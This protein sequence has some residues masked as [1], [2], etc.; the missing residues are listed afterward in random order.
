MMGPLANQLLAVVPTLVF[1]IYNDNISLDARTS[2]VPAPASKSRAK[3]QAPPSIS[4]LMEMELLRDQ[5]V[6]AEADCMRQRGL[7]QKTNSKERREL[8][9][10]KKYK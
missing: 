1:I 10:N 4:A 8:M 7:D 9:E 3:P 2:L 6:Y 5:L